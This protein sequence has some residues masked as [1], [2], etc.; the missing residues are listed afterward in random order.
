MDVRLGILQQLH[1][2]RAMARQVAAY[3][4]DAAVPAARGPVDFLQTINLSECAMR[5]A[6]LSRVVDVA[7]RC[8][9]LQRISLSYNFL[10]D[11]SVPMLAS[12]T[13][14]W[15]PAPGTPGPDPRPPI[16][17]SWPT[18]SASIWAAL[19]PRTQQSWKP[20]WA[21]RSAI[22]SWSQRRR[23][24]HLRQGLRAQGLRAR[25]ARLRVAA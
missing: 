15:S 22:C 20:R 17:I 7:S 12:L 9:Q 25:G 10:T 14:T 2:T 6:D 18:G 11:A 5:D 8:R 16:R 21:Q 19:S 24:Q 4:N 13:V 1:S 23:V 3:A